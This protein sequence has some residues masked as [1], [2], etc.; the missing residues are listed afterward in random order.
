MA[1][2]PPQKHLLLSH[3]RTASNLLLRILAIDE[4]PGFFPCEKEGY[5][6]LPTVKHRF[7]TAEKHLCEWTSEER[8]ELSDCHQ[9]CFEAL[10]KHAEMAESQ[11]KSVYV[12]EHAPWLMDPV[13][14]T[15]VMF[16]QDS[17][18]EEP[19]TVRAKED[20]TRSEGNE[21]VLPDEVLKQWCPTFL[22][23]HPALVFPSLYRTAVDLQGAEAAKGDEAYQKLEMTLRWSRRLYEWYVRQL[24]GADNSAKVDGE[25]PLVLDADDVMTDRR[26]LERYSEIVGL[27]ATKLK[28]SWS[29]TG[30]GEIERMQRFEKRMRSTLLASAGIVQGKTSVG[31]DMREEAG[32][33]KAEFGVGAAEK[34]EGWVNA[35]MFDYEYM[36]ANRLRPKD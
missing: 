20:Q 2:N 13:V 14:E 1:P 25:W 31:L 32:K 28:F 8:S 15:R 7:K 33:W 6:F 19:W 5:F 36:R 17:V 26:V 12:K 23:R 21:T 3:P 30:D 22:I 24:G 9:S 11:G 29:S 4:Q 27:D 18:V 35:A 10:Q 16:G 34:I